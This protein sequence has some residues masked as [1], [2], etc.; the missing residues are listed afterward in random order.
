VVRAVVVVEPYRAAHTLEALGLL[1]R[2]LQ[3]ELV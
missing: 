1:V 2:A 3:V